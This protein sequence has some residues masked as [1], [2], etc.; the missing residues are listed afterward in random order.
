ME[1]G[2]GAWEQPYIAFDE[3]LSQGPTSTRPR[4]QSLQSTIKY[5]MDSHYRFGGTAPQGFRD[6]RHAALHATLLEFI[7]KE[8]T[9]GV[10]PSEPK[11]RV[12]SLTSLSSGVLADGW[13]LAAQGAGREDLISAINS[14]GGWSTVAGALGLQ[15]SHSLREVYFKC[16]PSRRA[17]QEVEFT[18]P[19]MP[20]RF[21]A[22]IPEGVEPGYAS[23]PCLRSLPRWLAAAV[24]LIERVWLLAG[25]SS[26]CGCRRCCRQRRT[27]LHGAWTRRRQ[28]SGW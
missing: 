25:M 8:G 18:L 27:D 10:M 14:A 28:S 19:G 1:A 15:I 21:A 9:P 16:P 7:T 17:G 11:L 6:P 13:A 12:R 24:S 26:S 23:Q 4:S 5:D 22:T 20:Q 2:G 3:M